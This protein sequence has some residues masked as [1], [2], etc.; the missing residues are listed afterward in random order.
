MKVIVLNFDYTYLNTVSIEAAMGYLINGKV[1]VE[2]YSEKVLLTITREYIVPLVVR[3][4][5]FVRSVYKR[6]VEWKNRNVLVR[7][8]Y[9]CV[10]CGSKEKMTVDHVHPQCKGGK[11][12]FENTVA[13]CWKCNNRKGDKSLREAGMFF[14]NRHFRPYAPTV[15]EFI[16]KYHKNLG[17]Y[18]FLKELG[19]YFG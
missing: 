10:Y 8:N 3:L 18:E 11:D 5:H 7:D 19:I 17:V 9:T 16:R 13:A 14:K 1:P 2:K 6:R 15:M 12:T 4:T